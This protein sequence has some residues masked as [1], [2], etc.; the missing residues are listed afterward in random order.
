MLSVPHLV[1][2]VEKAERDLREASEKDKENKENKSKERDHIDKDGRLMGNVK[3][4]FL[5]P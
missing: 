2:A 4:F 1:A 5:K 3:L